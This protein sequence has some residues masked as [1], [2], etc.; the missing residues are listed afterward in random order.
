MTA[1]SNA[2]AGSPVAAA[3]IAALNHL[4][5]QQGWPLRQLS[6]FAGRVARL[7]FGALALDFAIDHRG[8]FAAAPA[9][10]VPDMTVSLPASALADLADG[11][12]GVMASARIAGSADLAE[13]LGQV[14][15]H[16][17]WDV[18]DDFARL[19]GDIAA[20]RLLIAARTAGRWLADSGR[21][22]G[23]AGAEY[24][25]YEQPTLVARPTLA[26][27]AAGCAEFART[28]DQL[29]ARLDQLTRRSG[30]G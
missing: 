10:S 17:R 13:T 18:E 16:L 9:G 5:R 4:L 7:E 1:S 30:A 23:E 22:L 12:P 3:A 28:L 14:L 19:V 24:L 6:P 11:L 2:V 8:L 25:L 15:R 27:H 26:A 21:S 29:D 20:R